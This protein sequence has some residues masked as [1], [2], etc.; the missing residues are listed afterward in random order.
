MYL[1]LNLGIYSSLNFKFA[2]RGEAKYKENVIY[3]RVIFNSESIEKNH[4]LM[5]LGNP[6]VD[7]KPLQY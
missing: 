1:L 6:L 4:K 2:F 7:E 5:D 3:S